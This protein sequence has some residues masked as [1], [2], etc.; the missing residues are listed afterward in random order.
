MCPTNNIVENITLKKVV[1]HGGKGIFIDSLKTEDRGELDKVLNKRI[2]EEILSRIGTQDEDLF[3]ILKNADIDYV[4]YKDKPL[5]AL[6][7]KAVEDSTNKK[8]TQVEAEKIDRQLDKRGSNEKVTEILA[9][10]STLEDNPFLSPEIRR[11]KTVELAKIAGLNEPV[12]E[13]LQKE[14]IDPEDI[15][16]FCIDDLVNKNI[17]SSKEGETLGFVGDISRLSGSNLELVKLL[18]ASNNKSV[19]DYIGW[20]RADWKKLIDDND[21]L[22]PVGEKRTDFYAETLRNA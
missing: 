2:K 16:R 5:S 17:L 6:V 4:S 3:K 8:L 15:N 7:K 10:D 18:K 21:I 1:F 13:K 19:T 22:L 14:N 20:D 9:L 11:L 12:I